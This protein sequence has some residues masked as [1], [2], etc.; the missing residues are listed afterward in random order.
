MAQ[1]HS[2][3]LI[4]ALLYVEPST[5]KTHI[6]NIYLKAQIDTEDR[7]SSRYLLLKKLVEE[8]VIPCPYCPCN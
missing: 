1:G 4:A 7:Q 2:N 5:I 6:R 8:G 3:S